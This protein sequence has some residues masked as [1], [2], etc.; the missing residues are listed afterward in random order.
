MRILFYLS[1]RTHQDKCQGYLFLDGTMADK[2]MNCP[3]LGEGGI[4]NLECS[5]HVPENIQTNTLKHNVQLRWN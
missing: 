2:P 4:H 3:Q 1:P 5:I